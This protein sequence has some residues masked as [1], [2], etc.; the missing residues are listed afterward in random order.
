MSY[1]DG[2]GIKLE[3]L[4]LVGKEFLHILALVSLELDHLSHLSVD[5]NGTI[6]SC[7]KLVAVLRPSLGGRQHTELL[8]DDLEDL[9]LVELLWQ[10]LDG[11]QSLATI[12]LWNHVRGLST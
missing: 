5:D 4:F 1:L 3:A 12:A 7:I 10:T 11:S 8:L 9:L 6:A 2:L